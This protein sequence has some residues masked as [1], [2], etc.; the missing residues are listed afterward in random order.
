[1]AAWQRRMRG[2]G[3]AAALIVGIGA[4][5]AQSAPGPLRFPDTALE[6]LAFSDLD[7][8]A[9]DDHAKAFAAFRASCAPLVRS[10]APEERPLAAALTQVCLR[11]L[12]LTAVDEAKARAFFEANFRPLRI[13][14]LGDTQGFL[15]GYYEPIVEGSRFPTREFTVPLYRRPA[16]LVSP[17]ERKAEAFPNRGPAFRRSGHRPYRAVEEEGT[18]PQAQGLLRSRVERAARGPG[19]WA[20]SPGEGGARP[21][22]SKR[23]ST[24]AES[25]DSS[26]VS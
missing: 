2:L 9:A 15:T 18:A 22:R 8:W 23:S 6:P 13:N 17:G 25:F 10:R 1:M 7:G 5:H 3:F 12:A 26:P 16:D 11:A 4:A 20:T 19:S 24:A 14:R 21:A